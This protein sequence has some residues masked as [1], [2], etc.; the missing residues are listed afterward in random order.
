MRGVNVS[1]ANHAALLTRVL[2]PALLAWL[3]QAGPPARASE[4]LRQEMAGFARAIKKVLDEEKQGAVVVGPFTGPA[5]LATNSG[6]GLQQLLIG[7]LQALEVD[8]RERA[9]LSV[10]GQYLTVEDD[11]DK[12]GLAL[13]LS[14]V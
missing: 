13:R 8:V 5:G 11:K 9:E 3:W 7:E 2:L 10:K 12:D 4:A 6:P 1:K 14:A